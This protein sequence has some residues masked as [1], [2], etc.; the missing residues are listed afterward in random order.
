MHLMFSIYFIFQL[1]LNHIASHITFCILSFQTVSPLIP[2]PTLSFPISPLLGLWV[3]L[4]HQSYREQIQQVRDKAEGKWSIP[5]AHLEANG[6]V[7]CVASNLMRR[8]HSPL[9]LTTRKIK[10]DVYY[11]SQA[12]L[13]PFF[14]S[15]A[16]IKSFSLEIY[17]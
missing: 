9:S 15:L 13:S 4:R 3:L 16:Y 2:S 10:A 17:S 5:K 11:Y 14:C 12:Y 6:G 1:I 8:M 7:V